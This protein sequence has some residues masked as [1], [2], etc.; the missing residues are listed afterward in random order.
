MISRHLNTALFSSSSSMAY[1]HHELRSGTHVK[2]WQKEGGWASPFQIPF[3]AISFA[4]YRAESARA[5][6]EAPTPGAFGSPLSLACTSTFANNMLHDWVSSQ[7]NT[8]NRTSDDGKNISIWGSPVVCLGVF[9]IELN[10]R[11]SIRKPIAVFLQ[12]DTGVRAIAPQGRIL[13]VQ[14]DRL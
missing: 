12:L 4:C 11:G 5:G 6:S 8:R 13:W 2:S 3:S 14:I 7:P 9:R 10:S 1:T